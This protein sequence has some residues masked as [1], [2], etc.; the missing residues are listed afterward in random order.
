M[1]EVGW[2][3]GLSETPSGPVETETTW[4]VNEVCLPPQWANRWY[5]L[6]V[7][8]ESPQS[9]E[10]FERVLLD[11]FSLGTSASCRLDE[12]DLGAGP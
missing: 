9:P 3:L 7:K 8:V 12:A 5:R 6:A 1:T 10:G 2:A 11:D 4:E